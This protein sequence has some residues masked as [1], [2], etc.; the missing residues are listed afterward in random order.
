MSVCVHF[1][2]HQ[3]LFLARV[4]SFVV[5]T[6]IACRLL[7]AVSLFAANRLCLLLVGRF[8]SRAVLA[9]SSVRL[10]RIFS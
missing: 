3:V 2:G 4:Y 5:F 7:A 9:Y 8:L 1:S 10:V 6:S